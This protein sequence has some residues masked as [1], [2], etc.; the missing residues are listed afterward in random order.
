L[1]H[2]TNQDDD[3][4]AAVADALDEL[5]MLQRADLPLAAPG[6][7]RAART[8]DWGYLKRFRKGKY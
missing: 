8:T 4:A 7:A 6:D 3:L 5:A 2:I 1:E